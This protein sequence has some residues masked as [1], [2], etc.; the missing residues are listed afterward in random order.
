MILFVAWWVVKFSIYIWSIC[1]WSSE[2]VSIGLIFPDLMDVCDKVEWPYII[3]LHI[4]YFIYHTY[5]TF[6]YS[7]THTHACVWCILSFL[8][9]QIDYLATMPTGKSQTPNEMPM[10]VTW[11]FPLPDIFLFFILQRACFHGTLFVSFVVFV[12]FVDTP[13]SRQ[14]PPFP[15][16][17]FGQ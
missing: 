17:G 14:H 10:D 7:H 5:H 11:Q 6:H 4:T 13:R 16:F 1:G 9:S 3:Y 12:C 8:E 2:A 15:G